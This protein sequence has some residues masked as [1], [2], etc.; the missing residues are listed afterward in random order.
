MRRWDW[1]SKRLDLDHT[2][3]FRRHSLPAQ[4]KPAFPRPLPLRTLETPSHLILICMSRPHFAALRLAAS[5]CRGRP[6]GAGGASHRCGRRVAA[7]RGAQVLSPAPQLAAALPAALIGHSRELQKG[8]SY[9][10]RGFC[11]HHHAAYAWRPAAPGRGGVAAGGCS[12]LPPLR[13]IAYS[14]ALEGSTEIGDYGGIM[15]Q[16]LRTALS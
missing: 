8:R 9:T 11:V 3:M 10:R 15:R 1:P 5:R 2:Q 6:R 14:H 12:C 16:P 4:P 13:W 7:G